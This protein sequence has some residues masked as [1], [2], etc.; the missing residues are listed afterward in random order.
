[1]ISSQLPRRNAAGR[2]LPDVNFQPFDSVKAFTSKAA[3][4][5]KV[6]DKMRTQPGDSVTPRLKIAPRYF[7]LFSLYL[8][9]FIVDSNFL[10][11]V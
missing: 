9:N 1:M 4:S 2:S 3:P 10:V 11:C 6:Q 5:I 8:T 7:L